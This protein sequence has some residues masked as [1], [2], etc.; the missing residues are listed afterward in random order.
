MEILGNTY[1]LVV[2]PKDFNL[3]NQK[4]FFSDFGFVV[5]SESEFFRDSMYDLCIKCY[6][7]RRNRFGPKVI[8]TIRKNMK[9]ITRK[10]LK[11]ER[12]VLEL[13]ALLLEITY[14]T[15][16]THDKDAHVR[17]FTT[18]DERSII[19]FTYCGSVDYE[20]LPL[21]KKIQNRVNSAK[22]K[23]QNGCF[24]KILQLGN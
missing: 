10:S 22:N 3:Y 23:K 21:I 24:F 8:T 11:D 14:Y 13:V 4:V 12:A 9:A 15:A 6:E 16:V 20:R 1:I 5:V 7:I 2:Y 18:I 19:Y 17:K